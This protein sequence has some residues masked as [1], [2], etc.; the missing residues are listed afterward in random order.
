[1]TTTTGADPREVGRAL[2][3][4]IPRSAHAA[5]DVEARDRDPVGVLEEQARTRVSELVPVRY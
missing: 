3:A 5:W 1:M 4:E 2:R